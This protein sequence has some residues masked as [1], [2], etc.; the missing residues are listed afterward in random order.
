MKPL[1]RD[2]EAN[3]SIALAAPLCDRIAVLFSDKLH[4]EVPSLETDLMESGILDSLTLVE[5]LF[6]IEQE[7]GFKISLE[8]VDLDHFRSI[9]RIADFLMSRNGSH[10]N[11]GDKTI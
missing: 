10:R 4:I 8:V 7:L 3:A 6:H 11:G 2:G 1:P 9:A 5:L